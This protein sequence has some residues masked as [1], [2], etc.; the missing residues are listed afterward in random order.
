MIW[1]F[2]SSSHIRSSIVQLIGSFLFVVAVCLMTWPVNA[3]TTIEEDTGTP[4]SEQADTAAEPANPT[5]EDMVEGAVD[6]SSSTSESIVKFPDQNSLDEIRML[7][8]QGMLQL[9]YS[10][11]QRARPNY[12]F[13]G[14]WVEWESAFFNVARML[15][16]WNGIL[17]RSKQI[18]ENIPYEFYTELQMHAI[19]AGLNIGQIDVAK[20]RLRH[21]IWELPYDQGKMIQWRELMVQ[22][23]LAEGALDEARVA[24]S[25]YFRDYRPSAPEWEHRYARTLFV[26]GH[27]QEALSRVAALQTMESKLLVLYSDYLSGNRAPL[28]VI[29]AGLELV[30]EFANRPELELELWALVGSA[31]RDVNDLELQVT[32]IENGLSVDYDTEKNSSRVWIVEPTTEQQLLDAYAELAVSVGYDFNLVIGDDLRWYGL[33]Q[34]FDITA[35]VIARS[36]FAFLAMQT[37]NLEIY[38]ASVFDMAENLNSSGLDRLMD[39][40]YVRLKHFDI[41]AVSSPIQT[42]LANRAIRRKDYA[43]ALAIMVAMDEPEDPAELVIHTLRRARTAVA[44]KE[45]EVAYQLLARLIEDLHPEVEQT[46]VDRIMHVIFDLQNSE[47]H[48]YAIALFRSLYDK[49]AKIQTKREILRWVSESLSAQIKNVEASEMLLRSARLGGKWDDNWGRSARLEAADQLVVSEFY[50]D[51]RILYEELKEDS[52]D[53]RSKALISNRIRNLPDS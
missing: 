25:V 44:V 47:I 40:L 15:N 12:E 52:L 32:A 53:P 22:C 49:T 45:Y 48:E 4:F 42:K 3:Q 39:S 19:Y 41:T 37:S 13:T 46:T 34:E 10:S 28:E 30:S 7:I 20:D 2:R 35:P 24:M 14:D 21:L 43:T 26:T 5:P 16:D 51:A 29:Q 1:A 23:Y 9:A 8:D 36:I 6:D 33:G 18:S 27:Y 17:T 31:A 38:K 50:D 11:L